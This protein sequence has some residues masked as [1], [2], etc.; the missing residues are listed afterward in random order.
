MLIFD[1]AKKANW[2]IQM[3]ELQKY[4]IFKFSKHTK[5]KKKLTFVC[6]CLYGFVYEHFILVLGQKVF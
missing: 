2:Q 6:I 3:L 5:F 4:E 1:S